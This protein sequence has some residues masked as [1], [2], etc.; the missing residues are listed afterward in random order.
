MNSLKAMFA[1][2]MVN[3]GKRPSNYD[4]SRIYYVDWW[5][6]RFFSAKNFASALPRSNFSAEDKSHNLHVDLV[7]PIPLW[8]V[9][10]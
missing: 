8:V 9:W 1:V 3:G 6:M 7:D 5:V 10:S 4:R 2:A